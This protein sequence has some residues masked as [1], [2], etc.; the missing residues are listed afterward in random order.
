MDQ[1]RSVGVFAIAALSLLYL[2]G[3]LVQSLATPTP[4]TANSTNNLTT[5]SLGYSDYIFNWDS[6]DGSTSSKKVDWP[7][8]FIFWDDANI[9][10]VK[11]RLDGCGGDPSL[12]PQVC[13]SS[14]TKYFR[15]NDGPET[16]YFEEV[17]W[18]GGK[19]QGVSCDYDQHIRVYAYD[20][21]GRNY[22]ASLGFYVMGTVHKDLEGGGCENSYYSAEGEEGWWVTRAG[23]ISGWSVTSG[24]YLSN[25]E[26]GRWDTNHWIQSDGYSRKVRVT[27]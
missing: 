27:W 5:I 24:P 4:A 3:G 9:N 15:F 21:T 8:R 22:N 18:D 23:Q 14:S 6:L 26:S 13:S 11:D 1:L 7:V 10:R 20:L 25:Y 12:S 16:Q 17:D 19:K 2:A